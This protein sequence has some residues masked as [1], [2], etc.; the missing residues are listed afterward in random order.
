MYDTQ[1][2]GSRPSRVI[3]FQYNPDQIKR[4]LAS[5]TPEKKESSAGAAKEEV[6]RVAG[7]PLETINLSVVLDA[8]DQL[9]DPDNNRNTVEHGIHP[10]LAT[11][12]MLLY[13][14][15]GRAEQIEQMAGRGKVQVSPAD[16]P[17]TLL[18]WGKSRVVPVLLTGFS[19]SEEAFDRNLNPIKAK[20][21]LAMKVLTYVE[22]PDGCLARDTFI[23]YQKEKESLAGKYAAGEDDRGK[24]MKLLPGGETPS[25]DT[26]TRQL[27]SS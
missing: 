1:T 5:R 27:S 13:P 18:V 3:V 19:V 22:F 23:I 10:A 8:T 6:M 12:E 2:T 26:G 24:L 17:L 25:Q 16:L 20:V 11:L 4:T 14:P 9:E 21:E 7:P 15:A